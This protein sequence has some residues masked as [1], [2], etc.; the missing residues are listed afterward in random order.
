MM[1]PAL[2]VA[3]LLAQAQPAEPARKADPNAPITMNGCVTRD[4]TD[5]KNASAYTFVDAIDGG[6]YHLKGKSLSRYSGM[7][8]QVVGI[9]DTKKLKVAG[10]L[11]PSPNV[12]GQAGNIDPGKAAIAA[13]PGGPTTGVGNVELPTLNV[14]RLSLGEG[15]CRK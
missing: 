5:S 9:I 13:L 2:A 11:W 12:A 10:G 3:L 4:Y 8:V 6:R 1:L 15:E 7:S 14:T